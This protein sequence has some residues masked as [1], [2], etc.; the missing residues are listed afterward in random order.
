VVGVPVTGNRVGTKV[1]AVVSE[2]VGACVVGIRVVGD[3]VGMRVGARVGMRVGIGVVG[4]SVTG[5]RVGAAVVAQ[6][7][8]PELVTLPSEDHEIV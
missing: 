7:V 5:N 6:S 8:Y 3:R 2:R 4:V 1:G